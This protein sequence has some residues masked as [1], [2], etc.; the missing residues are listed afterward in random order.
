MIRTSLGSSALALAPLA[1]ALAGCGSPAPMPTGGAAMVDTNDMMSMPM[2][3]GR[4]VDMTKVPEFPGAVMVDMKIM[5]HEADDMMGYSF[6][7]PS[8]PADV[9]AWYKAALPK[10][11]FSVTDDKGALVGV[12]PDRAPFRLDLKSAPGGHTIGTISKG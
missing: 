11:G 7:A 12:G 3:D 9:I 1:L 2:P 5:P 8:P 4:R 10:A 6:D